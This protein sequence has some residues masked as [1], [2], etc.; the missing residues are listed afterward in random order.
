[1]RNSASANLFPAK[2]ET[3]FAHAWLL[4]L[5]NSSSKPNHVKAGGNKYDL[6]SLS[7]NLSGIQMM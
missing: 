1:M 7:T 6:T 4:Q 5:L 3:D 2:F